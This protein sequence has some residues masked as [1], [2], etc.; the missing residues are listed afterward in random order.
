MKCDLSYE[1]NENGTA[2][3]YTTIEINGV[4]KKMKCANYNNEEQARACLNYMRLR[5]NQD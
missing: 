2:T 4:K 5:A 1:V 3:I